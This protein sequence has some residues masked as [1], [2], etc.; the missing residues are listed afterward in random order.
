MKYYIAGYIDFFLQD[1]KSA[2]PTKNGPLPTK[3]DAFYRNTVKI[4][5]IIGFRHCF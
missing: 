2:L 1:R 3:V 5:G 4:A